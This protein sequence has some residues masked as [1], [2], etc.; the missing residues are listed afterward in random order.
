LR[1]NAKAKTGT[2]KETK[3]KRRGRNVK[4]I[5][6]DNTRKNGRSRR[7]RSESKQVNHPQLYQVY[8][9]FIT[10]NFSCRAFT[11][12]WALFRA[13]KIVPLVGDTLHIHLQTTDVLEEGDSCIQ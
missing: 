7:K 5:K 1:Q 4:G 12:D 8:I 13:G 3:V 6:K 11:W 2:R 10:N 9:Y